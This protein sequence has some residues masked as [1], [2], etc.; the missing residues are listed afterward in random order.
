MITETR[1]CFN[2]VHTRVLSVPGDGVP[3]VMFH[4]YADSADTWRG[5]LTEVE[6]AGR[7]AVAVD[8]PGFGAADPRTD[9]PMLPQFDAF[10]DART[11]ACSASSRVYRSRVWWWHG[12]SGEGSGSACMDPGTRE[13]QRSST[14]G[15]R[16]FGASGSAVKAGD[17]GGDPPSDCHGWAKAG[18]GGTAGRGLFGP[19]G[20]VMARRAA[21]AICTALG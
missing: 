9:G 1:A 14:A 10:A 21:A 18:S 20:A 15:S 12:R 13:I 3:I 4:G 19:M 8:L 2:G 5:V 16:R 7:R 11:A 6:A 17:A